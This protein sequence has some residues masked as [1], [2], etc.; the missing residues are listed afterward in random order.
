[1][2]NYTG[3]AALRAFVNIHPQIQTTPYEVN[4]FN[5]YYKKGLNWYINQMPYLFVNQI[6][7]EKT[8][9]YFTSN[10]V[11]VAKL[12]HQMNPKMKLIL[13]VKNPVERTISDYAQF[14]HNKKFKFNPESY[15]E[16]SKQFEKQILN[17]KGS[18]IKF[19][20]YIY[21]LTNRFFFFN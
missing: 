21:H 14:L 5:K 9:A 18:I 15:D 10:R 1:M 11:N 3:T 8:P 2:L 12:I 6:A 7:I 20:K 16:Y 19:N 13:L 17:K 4:F